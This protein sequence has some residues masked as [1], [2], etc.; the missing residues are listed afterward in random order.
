ME[1]LI[2]GQPVKVAKKSLRINWRTGECST[3]S[4]SVIDMDA[5]TEYRRG[6]PVEIY[7]DDD[8]LVFSGVI[9]KAT[10]RHE[11]QVRIHQLTGRCWTYLADK[12]IVAR[13]WV[14]AKAGDIVRDIISDWLSDEGVTE[15]TIHEGPEIA[16]FLANYRP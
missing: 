6:E 1:V 12:R 7:D 8:V 9:D 10:F 13:S 4:L 5:S 16:E 15:G 2:R 11:D 3:C 14:G